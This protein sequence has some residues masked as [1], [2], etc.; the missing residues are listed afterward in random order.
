MVAQCVNVK[1]Q[2]FPKPFNHQASNFYCSG[3]AIALYL[4][5]AEPWGNPMKS[6][7]AFLALLG[8]CLGG[9]ASADTITTGN[10]SFDCGGCSNSPVN[11]IYDT[12]PSD[13]SFVY[14]NTT[15]HFLS[16]IFSWNGMPFLW[17]PAIPPFSN[18]P[19]LF[20]ELTAANPVPLRFALVC[21]ASDPANCGDLFNSEFRDGLGNDMT[22]AAQNGVQPRFA[23]DDSAG[24]VTAKDDTVQTPEPST[25]L[26][27]GIG[28]IGLGLLSRRD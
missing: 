26:L 20:A 22:F 5:L 7:L 24:V 25:L 23:N 15:G 18:Q 16:I 19:Q 2:K 3:C 14:D 8:V 10:L 9:R 17:D 6:K 4:L 13:G 12:S 28:A 11:G 1:R 21:S 27:L